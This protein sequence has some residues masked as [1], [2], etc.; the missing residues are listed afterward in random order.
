MRLRN[1]PEAKEIVANSQHVLHIK[2]YEAA[3]PEDNARPVH[4]EIGM[5]KGSFIIESAIRHP[6]IYF[7][8]IERYESVLFRAVQAMDA[9]EVPPENVKFMCMDAGL[10]PDHFGKGEVERIYLNFSDPWPKARHAKRRL[11]SS[12]FLEVYEKVLKDGGELHFKTDNTDLFDFSVEEI[13]G[14][15]G[16]DL[17]YVTYDLHREL[18]TAADNTENTQ[19]VREN[20]MTEYEEKFSLLGNKICKLEAVYRGN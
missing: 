17:T 1:I 18:K 16:W 9:M 20:V 13:G 8:G 6:E 4:L 10:I 15:E 14:R 3:A 5:G 19:K 11:T 12:R 2:D 7:V